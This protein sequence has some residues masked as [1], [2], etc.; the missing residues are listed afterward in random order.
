M[1]VY[2]DQS[3]T[4]SAQV[5]LE[6]IF[7]IPALH[8]PNHI[9]YEITSNWK[10]HKLVDPLKDMCQFKQYLYTTKRYATIRNWDNMRYP[11]TPYHFKLFYFHSLSQ[12]FGNSLHEIA[13]FFI[14]LLI[15][16]QNTLICIIQ[17]C[18]CNCKTFLFQWQ[19][20]NCHQLS[21]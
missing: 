13:F 18:A 11:R 17:P 16:I 7:H 21:H 9:K 15:C 1:L 5:I 14:L 4:W 19:K 10:A 20:E 6:L 8:H 3:I 12:P 2:C